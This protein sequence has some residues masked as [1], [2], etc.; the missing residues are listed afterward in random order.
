[1]LV[2]PW[3]NLSLK[4]FSWRFF[5]TSRPD[6]ISTISPLEQARF[7]LLIVGFFFFL[8]FLIVMG[9]LI[10][11]M[12]LK[13]AG[14]TPIEQAQTQFL[15]GQVSRGDIYD[16]TGQLLATNLVT[17]SLYANPRVLINP[18]EAADKL[19]K[20]FPDLNKKALLEKLSSD[21]GF[22]WIKRNIT[23]K[24]QD[25][26]NQ[27][28]IPGLYFE[29][30]ERRLYPHGSLFSH[31]IGF[32]DLD[33]QGLAGIE[34]YFNKDLLKPSSSLQISLDLRVQHVLREEIIK[35]I[36]KFHAIGGNGIIMD[37]NTDEII[38]LVSVPDFDPNQPEKI[39]PATLFN[40]NT[41]GI[42][43]MGS[44]YKAFSMAMALESKVTS[45][46]NG[47]DAT[48]P[49][50]AGR[51][52]IDDHHPKRRWLTVPE[53]FIYSSN[54]GTIKMILEVGIERQKK[55]LEALNLL[56]MPEFELFEIGAPLVPQQWREITSMS[57]S[58]GYGLSISSL[59]LVTAV[60]CL[61]NGGILYKPT[62]L[63]V[64]EGHKAEGKR[65]FS[66]KTSDQMR[67]LFRLV[68]E[69]GTGRKAN[70]PGYLVGGK[71]G[72]INKQ[73]GKTYQKSLTV[74]T[75]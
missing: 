6:K 26:I 7:R 62:L 74:A 21:R 45:L 38:A 37:V 71:S 59:Q 50:K 41:L 36:E 11:V 18:Q 4:K 44:V 72:S 1:M 47:Y 68:V 33:N 67:R 31:I 15:E 28:G 32:T 55:F 40:K 13:D 3:Q 56:K 63:K 65:V 35:G 64:G 48:H 61:V 10:D 46:K 22:V 52:T 73:V 16:R 58:Y 75:F 27:L 14:V 29:R 43:E 2:H 25:A 70:V 54:I 69:K 20:L 57:I 24:Q 34:R 23:P 51:F 9:R 39:S 12:V 5:K 19:Y 30:E 53:I 49:I 60:S 42:Y 66:E 17:A 8:A